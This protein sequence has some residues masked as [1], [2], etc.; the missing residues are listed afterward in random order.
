MD[1]KYIFEMDKGQYKVPVSKELYVKN[2]EYFRG[3]GLYDEQDCQERALITTGF[4][5]VRQ[6]EI[7]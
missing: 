3:M 7:E 6:N 5:V 4:R 1:I 2:F